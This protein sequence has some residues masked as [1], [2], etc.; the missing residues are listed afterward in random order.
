MW[1][2]R[3]TVRAHS[4]T[5]YRAARAHAVTTSPGAPPD[6]PNVRT[7]PRRLDRHRATG[8]RN[9]EPEE[10][11]RLDR[12]D[13][14]Y[15]SLVAVMFN[16]AQSGHPGGSVSVGPDRRALPVRRV[17]TTTSATRSGWTRTSSPTRRA[18]RR[19]G[20]TPCWDLRDEVVRRR[21]PTDPPRRPTQD[22]L[23]GH[24]GLPA[25]PD[26]P[27]P[28][29]PRSSAPR[30]S[31]ATRPRR[32]RSYGSPPGPSGVGMGGSLGLAFGAADFFGAD[33]PR[34]HII[35]G[36][37]GLTPGR[38]YEAVAFAGTS[39]PLQRHRPPRLEP[40]VHRLRSR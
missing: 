8:R 20:S 21:A 16:F 31:T 28:A 19:W 39:G 11:A 40:G 4:A 6:E 3:R 27:D 1:L 13:L 32:P 37:G 9:P 10:L 14:V 12:V 26:P 23:R 15:R 17:W 2:V 22:A 35:E 25:Q 24:A 18:T 38:V 29:V 7:P 33:A 34:V 30:R 36:E 5:P